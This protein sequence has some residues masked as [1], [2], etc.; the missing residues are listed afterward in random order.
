MYSKWSGECH[1]F[2]HELW[3]DG[4]AAEVGICLLPV[5]RLISDPQGFN[6]CWSRIVFGFTPLSYDQLDRYSLQHSIRYT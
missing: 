2:F 3:K 6:P 4:K 1:Q 5:T